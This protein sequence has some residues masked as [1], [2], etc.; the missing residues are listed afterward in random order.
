ME[1]SE[2]PRMAETGY[3]KYVRQV[4][5]EIKDLP[6]ECRQSGDDSG[7]KDVW[8]EYKYQIQHE[9]FAVSWAYGETIRSLCV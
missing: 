7:L 1:D 3:A 2:V 8:E 4:I 6:D 5:Q 9:E